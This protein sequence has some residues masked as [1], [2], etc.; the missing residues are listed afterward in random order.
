M[1]DHSARLS[2]C[3]PCDES[4]PFPTLLSLNILSCLS[5]ASSTR[6]AFL[7]RNTVSARMGLTRAHTGARVP[8]QVQRVTHERRP[9]RASGVGLQ[10]SDLHGCGYAAALA[11]PLRYFGS[12]EAR[13]ARADGVAFRHVFA[14]A[15]LVVDG[16]NAKAEEGS[17]FLRAHP[18]RRIQKIV[19]GRF[20][21]S[22]VVTVRS[23]CPTCCAVLAPRVPGRDWIRFPIEDREAE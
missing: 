19:I 10:F 23:R 9:D 8:L 22:H 16:L 1:R 3:G 17:E 11:Q 18:L 13:E 21:R 20:D 15:D 12:V 4:P 6:A 5:G 14:G 2:C 7:E